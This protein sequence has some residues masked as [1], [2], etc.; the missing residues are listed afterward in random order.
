MGRGALLVGHSVGSSL[1]SGSLG[2]GWLGRSG[3][4]SI[5]CRCVAAT[6]GALLGLPGEPVIVRTRMTVDQFG[7]AFN[8]QPRLNLTQ[9]SAFPATQTLYECLYKECLSFAPPLRTLH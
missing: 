6:A 9:K 7:G 3:S 5:D 2:P 8:L 1:N 4:V